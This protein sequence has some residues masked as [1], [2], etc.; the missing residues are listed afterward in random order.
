MKLQTLIA[1][2][3]LVLMLTA[4][5]CTSANKPPVAY[6]DSI[7]P[8][9]LQT[10]QTVTLT[11]HGT[12]EDGQIASYE[13]R[14]SIDG[15]LGNGSA[16]NTSILSAG[17][18]TISLKVCD[19]DGACSQEA[20]ATLVVSNA[21][22]DEESAA[23]AVIE[24]IIEPMNFDGPIIGFKLNDL[25]KPGD[26]IAPYRGDKRI[27]DEES[28]FYFIDLQPGAY[29]AHDTLFV[30]V[31][32]KDGGVNVSQEQWWP[33]VNNE[34]PS[35]VTDEDQYYNASNWFFDSG[36]N[37]PAGASITAPQIGM[38][39]P[40]HQWYEASVIV[41]GHHDGESLEWDA[42]MSAW[43]MWVLFDY[44]ITPGET[45]EITPPPT[46]SN[47]PD[48]MFDLLDQL[49]QDG[50]DHIITYIVNHGGTDVIAVGGQDLYADDLVDFLNAHPDTSF[51]FLIETCASGS[52]IDDLSE[53]PNVKLVLTATSSIYPSSAD[54]DPEYDPNPIDS[55]SEWT[56]SL[57][58]GALDRLTN[59]GWADICNEA[60]RISAP[61]SVVLLMSAF[62][63]IG[64]NDSRDLNACYLDFGQF[65]QAWSQYS[66]LC[67]LWQQPPIGG[68]VRLSPSDYYSGHVTSSGAIS[69]GEW[70]SIWIGNSDT[71]R[72]LV[73][74]PLPDE[75][76]EG[77]TILTASMGF[78]VW[79][80]DNCVPGYL[81]DFTIE[82]LVYDS[83]DASDFNT[84]GS[85][86]AGVQVWCCEESCVAHF[87]LQFADL[88]QQDFDSHHEYIQFRFKF[89]GESEVQIFTSSLTMYYELR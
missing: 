48:D 71:T 35:W 86:I 84:A 65:P 34:P 85:E 21:P 16:I 43:E 60:N 23:D 75:M 14:S 37:R 24:H 70:N 28:Y 18:H 1:V 88:M 4:A 46:G 83:L 31:D 26:T 57:Y 6:I 82:H 22:L 42:A 5:A 89:T 63:N 9:Y 33:I 51:S 50:Y 67:R 41:N 15:A 19:N 13:W 8:S 80:E 38:P 59:V 27:V 44:Y 77:S 68:E 45:Y 40:Q 78:S 36:V 54:W 2:S 12:D 55:G 10:G 72:Y 76:P 49:C 32:K 47:T 58:W 69:Y 53:L 25:L 62:N 3:L 87:P 56:S 11:G 39:A 29:Y 64:A 61:P 30:T 17:Q 79:T 81:G 66:S 74:Y 73:S 52:F 7:T 20:T